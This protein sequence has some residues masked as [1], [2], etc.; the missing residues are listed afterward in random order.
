[1]S[2]KFSFLL[3]FIIILLCLFSLNL[4]NENNQECKFNGYTLLIPKI[5]LSEQLNNESLNAGPLMDNKSGIPGIGPVYIFGHRLS[6][7][8]PFL[9]IDELRAGDNVSIISPECKYVSY[10]VFG[11][12]IVDPDYKIPI[13]DNTNLYLISCYPVGSNAKRIIVECHLPIN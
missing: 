6:M 3:L 4:I 7:K 5:N 12:Y 2:K 10:T 8:S 13:V 9:R 11:A 1:M